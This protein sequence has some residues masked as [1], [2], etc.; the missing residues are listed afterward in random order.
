[1]TP[2]PIRVFPS[3][4]HGGEYVAARI[5]AAIDTAANESRRC[6][7]GIPTGRTPM[8]ILAALLASLRA[9]PRRL[10]HLVI[11]LMDE[12]L[13]PGEHGLVHA[14]ATKPWSCHAFV[15]REL[16]APLVAMLPGTHGLSTANIWSPDPRDPGAYDRRLAEAGGI[17]LF[18][19]ASG[20]GDGHVAFNT[21]GS[22]R[23]GHTS[24]I[25]LSESTRRYN[26]ETFPIFGTLDEV[27]HHGVGVGIATLCT[28]RASMMVAWGHAKQQTVAR[29]RAA[30]MY[31]PDWPATLIHECAN[32]EIVVD[33]DA[34]GTS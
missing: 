20:A 12:Y 3:P 8:P 6:L 27:P 13:V 7:I 5:L 1:M 32:A 30:T 16:F 25:S 19:M 34:A 18:V 9:R 24:I 17:D 22:P 2:A 26:L 21:P 14:P 15:L 29:M 28:S 10:D 11:A 4:A 31:E 33:A 23:D